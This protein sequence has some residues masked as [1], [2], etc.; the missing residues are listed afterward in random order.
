MTVGHSLFPRHPVRAPRNELDRVVRRPEQLLRRRS[1]APALLVPKDHSLLSPKVPMIMRK[2]LHIL[3]QRLRQHLQIRQHR[4]QR[5]HT[6]KRQY[7]LP[8]PDPAHILPGRREVLAHRLEHGVQDAPR[9]GEDLRGLWVVL[10]GDEDE[11]AGDHVACE[12]LHAA[13]EDD[14]VGGALLG[15]AGSGA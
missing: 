9:L 15:C 11:R 2:D 8:I 5:P 3:L 7:L 13:A 10:P 6:P 12:E 14:G 4:L 1:P